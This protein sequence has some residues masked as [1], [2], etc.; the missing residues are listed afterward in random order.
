MPNYFKIF[1]L[2]LTG[3]YCRYDHRA[4]CNVPLDMPCARV[5]CPL[6]LEAIERANNEFHE[7]GRV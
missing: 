2:R 6:W 5:S 7:K 3:R 1:V 4:A